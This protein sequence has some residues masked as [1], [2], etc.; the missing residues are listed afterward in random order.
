MTTT[1]HLK[2]RVRTFQAGK[3]SSAKTEVGVLQKLEEGQK[4]GLFNRNGM[5][6]T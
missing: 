4:A 6:H 3:T 2:S 5:S 1:S